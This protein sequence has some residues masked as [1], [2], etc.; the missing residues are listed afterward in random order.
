[1]KRFLTRFVNVF[2]AVLIVGMVFGVSAP[3]PVMAESGVVVD[4]LILP[5][6]QT[7]VNGEDFT[8]TIE[9]RTSDQVV[10][11]IAAKFDYDDTYLTAKSI[12][13]YGVFDNEISTIST[14]GEADYDGF[15]LGG[16][17]NGT[18]TLATITFTAEAVT[19][20]TAL[21]FYTTLGQPRTTSAGGGVGEDVLRSVTNATVTISPGTLTS[22]N[23]T[24]EAPTISIGQALQFTANGTY[25]GG[26]A[27]ITDSAD[28]VSSLPGIATINTTGQ[29]NPGLAVALAAG[30]TGITASLDA[31]TSTPVRNLIVETG[32][33]DNITISPQS[34]AI[35]ADQTQSYTVNATNTY[36]GIWNATS[37]TTFTINTTAGGT[38]TG[39]NPKIYTPQNA[40]TWT[41]T[42]NHTATGEIDT[43]TLT[44]TPGAVDHITITPSSSTITA[45]ETEDYTAEAFDQSNNSLGDVTAGTAF[46]IQTGAGGS[47]SGTNPKVYTP[48]V[49]GTWTVTGTYA[50]ITDTATLTVNQ[51]AL[52]HLEIS[53]TTP[54]ITT[55]DTATFT[56]I[57]YDA[58]NNP[59]VFTANTTFSINGTAGGS[60]TGGNVYHPENVGNWT[61][62]GNHTATGIYDTAPLVVEGGA[63]VSIALSPS[64]S[65]KTAGETESYTVEASDSAAQTWDVTSSTTFSID[66]LAGGTWSGTGTNPKVYTT[67]KA[68]IWTVTATHTASGKTDTATLTVNAAALDSIVLSP[69]TATIT[70]DD[71]RGYSVEG[72]DQYLNTTGNVTAGTTF[73]IDAGAGGSF[74]GTNV[75]TAETVGTWTVTA[76]HTASG[77][78][79]TATLTVTLGALNTIE[80][81]T[82]PST[83]TADDTATFTSTAYDAKL[84]SWVVTTGTTFA[85]D[86]SAGGS[87]AANVYT[88]EN[89]G[90]WTVT[91]THTSS[92][93]TDPFTLTV[94]VGALDHIVISPPS[95]N[96]TAGHTTF[97]DW[98]YDF[99]TE[100]FDQHDNS[101]GNITDDTMWSSSNP[102]IASIESKGET[103]PGRAT[104]NTPGQVTITASNG[105]KSTT[106]TLTVTEPVIDSLVVSPATTTINMGDTQAF[107]AMVTYSDGSVIDKTTSA[108]W[109]SS[110]TDV[111]TIGSNGVAAT[112]NSTGSTTITANVSGEINTATLTVIDKALVSIAVT[113]AAQSKN[114]GETQLFIATGN[115]SDTLVV[116][117]DKV[118][119][120]SSNTTVAR[121]KSGGLATTYIAGTTNITATLDTMP[122]STT[123]TVNPATISSVKVTPLDPTITFAYGTTPTIQ[124]KA[125]TVYTDGS[126]TDNS[127]SA[128][129]NSDD[130][131]TANVTTDGLVTVKQAGTVTISAQ[132]GAAPLAESDLTIPADALAPVIKITSP[133][134][135]LVVSGTSITVTGTIDDTSAVTRAS[136]EVVVNG[137]GF[138]LVPDPDATSGNFSQVVTLNAGTNTIAVRATDAGPQ[139]GVS[140]TKTVVVNPLKPTIIITSPAE[141]SITSSTTATVQGTIVGGSSATLRVNGVAVATVGPTFSTL[142]NLSEG[143]NTI[144]A[145]GYATGESTAAYLGTS[146]IRTVT[147]DKTAPVLAIISPSS[148]AVVNTPGITVSGTVDDL[149]VTTA[150]LTLS[151]GSEPIP[152]T[153]GTFSHDVG[154]VTGANPISIVASDSLGNTSTAVSTT[155]TFDNTKP[156]VTVAAPAN[157]LLTNAGGVVVTGSVNDPSITT[158]TLYVNNVPQSM[159]V[160]G[161]SFSQMAAL[162]VGANTITVTATDGASNTGTSGVTNVTLDTTAPSINIGLTDPTTSVTITVTSNEALIAEPSVTLTPGGAISMTSV[163]INE[164]SGVFPS[165]T[166]GQSYTVTVVGTDKAGN[167]K[168]NTATFK[169]NDVTINVGSPLTFASG[170]TTLT[171][172]VT[173]NVTAP[174][175]ISITQSTENPAENTAS[176]TG[177][178]AFI[179]IVASGNLTDSIG[180]ID[181]QVTYDED[182][183]FSQGIEESSLKLYLWETTTGTWEVVPGSGVNTA[184]NYIF[185]TITHLS[186]YGGF[187]SPPATPP[188]PVPTGGGGE[189]DDLTLLKVT[190]I[191]V[192]NITGTSATI[193]WNTNE[194]STT[195]IEYWASPS[196]FSPLDEAMV[197]YHEVH[198]TGLSVATTYHYRTMSKDRVGNLV[199]SDEYTFTTSGTPAT[200]A[201]SSLSVSPTQVDIGATVTVSVT[202]KNTGDAS[203]SY[204]VILK[205][206][207]A[208]VET[209][210]GTLAG[211]ESQQVTFTTSKH[212]AGTYS[213][214]VNGL[215][216]TFTVKPAPP[217]PTPPA[218]T[219]FSI[220]S[221]SISPAEVDIGDRVTISVTVANTGNAAGGYEVTLKVNGAVVETKTATLAVG[222]SQQVTFT[223]SKNTAGTY[224]VDVN[225]LAGTFTVKTAAE[226]VIPPKP[227]NWWLIVG[228]IV[229]VI[230]IGLFI[231]R[232]MRRRIAG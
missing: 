210:T 112:N 223:T 214:D 222:S 127:S 67:E 71:T 115:Y 206:N 156:L 220:K 169:R 218:V 41:V 153:E 45:D 29:D 224:S 183:I 49:A 63:I 36:G 232:F 56:S 165:P 163:G 105:G 166:A 155:V 182:E 22:I 48:E 109:T 125:T 94:N 227:T 148:G 132:V 113:P 123:L 80:I 221:L 88:A 99:T 57:A 17:P 85:I 217:P 97:E 74:S 65:T 202:V 13:D 158:A 126:T 175:S 212:T 90:V 119:W 64:S 40:G 167:P 136:A 31:I 180:S 73:S 114:A 157:N 168:T 225:G 177:A 172:D 147:R 164:W 179:E 59:W 118:T 104:G 62:T 219:S 208:D 84:N 122:G 89:N 58:V 47:F 229:G 106:A 149:T 27:I 130:T 12:V 102:G 195:Q 8:V 211:G 68:G 53:T 52:H 18:F 194:K 78:I 9:A 54:T 141:G 1:M 61:V 191:A 196:M 46:S 231:W 161:G 82:S 5:A 4:L 70:A 184:A 124:F 198:L 10:S 92:G 142:V 3:Q 103:N 154:L 215:A 151:S 185:G 2:A 6:S 28:W 187:G 60:W 75:Y 171:I 216:G 117:T 38:F 30:T 83:I 25:T 55:D 76:T 20:S 16:F 101:R 34:S 51:G 19:S 26:D 203:G 145:S 79:D 14:S 230:I 66:T 91:G 188:P 134:D 140:G 135:G 21:T 50:T 69:A 72:F 178:G 128:V 205:I 137:V 207:D 138:D 139:T 116:I 160:V 150:T 129:W 121:I 87:W 193:V 108:T 200:F 174:Q 189:S 131:A 111:A 159:S 213:V 133:S 39:T 86:T 32:T 186:K 192:Q 100:A 209:K 190:D 7:V 197:T 143:K 37:E 77:E 201:V 173:S 144:I 170:T 226:E 152:V 181:I 35:N 228:I 43:A 81:S 98:G 146:G 96:I 33:A 44:V 15:N 107:R 204:V 11:G 42:A 120:S 162:N 93:K 23:V 199:I 110:D 176:G 24:P 95:G